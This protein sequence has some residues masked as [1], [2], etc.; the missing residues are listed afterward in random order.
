[1]Q[2]EK[3]NMNAQNISSVIKKLLLCFS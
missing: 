3:K 1:M 2:N